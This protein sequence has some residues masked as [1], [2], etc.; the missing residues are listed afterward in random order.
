[1]VQ[2]F[3]G[4]REPFPLPSKLQANVYVMSAHAFEHLRQT[5]EFGLRIVFSLPFGPG[6][7]PVLSPPAARIANA[8]VSSGGNTGGANAAGGFDTAPLTR[9]ASVQSSPSARR[10]RCAMFLMR[11]ACLWRGR[12]VAGWRRRFCGG[13]R[14]VTRC[15]FNDR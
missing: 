15:G 2:P 1:M 11:V 8:S 10:Q 5:K 9:A 4:L 6:R 14:A 13:R 3:F 12:R 7:M